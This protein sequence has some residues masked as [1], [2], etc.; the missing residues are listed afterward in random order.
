MS[1][2]CDLKILRAKR[3]ELEAESRT[4]KETQKNIE[5]RINVLEEKVA[6]NELE[7]NNRATRN[8]IFQ[9]ESTVRIL[10]NRLKAMSPEQKVPA[11]EKP[12]DDANS[13]SSDKKETPC[14]TEIAEEFQE[15]II[16]VEA[17]D[18]ESIVENEYDLKKK[19]EKKR[20][21]F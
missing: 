15:N 20:R 10:E 11:S 12:L 21:F 9:L 18:Q 6:L 16:I 17:I 4:L 1:E 8:S 2:T 13:T 19:G 7:N 3:A 5:S 14:T